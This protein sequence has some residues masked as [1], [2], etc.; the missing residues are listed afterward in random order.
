[1]GS[2][3]LGIIVLISTLIGL[4]LFKELISLVFSISNPVYL[5]FNIL[6]SLGLVVF[7]IGLLKLERWGWFGWMVIGLSMGL[8][9]IISSIIGDWS[10]IILFTSLGKTFIR[11]LIPCVY[12]WFRKEKFNVGSIKDE[13]ENIKFIIEEWTKKKKK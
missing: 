5:I 13:K 10:S 12:L 4:L 8:Y 11:Y 2:I 9:N 6:T 1:M 3:G 7:G